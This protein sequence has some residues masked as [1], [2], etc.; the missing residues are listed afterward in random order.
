MLIMATFPLKL[1]LILQFVF[2]TAPVFFHAKVSDVRC[3]NACGRLPHATDHKD[4]SHVP[5]KDKV[6][7]EAGSLRSSVMNRWPDHMD[8]KL[9]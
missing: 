4:L 7:S 2:L 9:C 5:E 6:T 8:S 1:S 3:E